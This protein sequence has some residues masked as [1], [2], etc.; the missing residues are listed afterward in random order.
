MM[1]TNPLGMAI[2]SGEKGKAILP[3]HIKPIKI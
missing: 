2:N 1:P 3:A